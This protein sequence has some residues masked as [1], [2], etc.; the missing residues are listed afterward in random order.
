MHIHKYEKYW[1]IF[2]IAS[3]FLFLGITGVMALS[4]G[5]HPP[6][7]MMAIDPEKVRST[8][9][10]DN[11]GLIQTGDNTYEANLIA[12]T[13][14]YQPNQLEI[15]VGAKVKFQVTSPDVVHSFTIVGTNVNMMITPGNVNVREYTFKKPGEYLVLCNEYCGTGHQLMTM[16]IKVVE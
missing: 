9:P 4:Q 2:G 12:M 15:P 10:F 14:G 1:L 5:H 6:S 16:T 8:P 13:F 3:L 7:G 11:P